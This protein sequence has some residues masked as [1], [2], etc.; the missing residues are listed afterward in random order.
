MGIYDRNRGVAGAR[1]NLWIR[2]TITEELRVKHGLKAREQREPSPEDNQRAA[3]ALLA[4]RNREVR[5]GSWQPASKGG[6]SGQTLREYATAWLDARLAAGVKS[7]RNERQRLVQ[8]V[9]PV[10]GDKRLGDVRRQDVRQLIADFA[11]TPSKTTGKPPAPR[12]VHRVYE[13]LR[14]LYAEAVEVDE[15]VPASPC[16]LKVRRGE[17][18]KKKDA[19]PRW[20]TNAVFSRDEVEMLISDERIDWPRRVTYALMFL[21]GSRIGEVCGLLWRDYDPTMR[22]LGRITVATTYGGEST[23][24]ETT[25]E[26]PVH[27]VLA[28]M[29]ASWKL[30]GFPLYLAR[31][32]RPDDYV[33]PRLRTRGGKPATIPHQDSRRVWV[34][35]QADLRMLGM[36]KR[37]VHDARRTLISLARADGATKDILDWITHGPSNE[38]MQDLYTT[39]PWSTFCEQLA[40]LRIELRKPAAVTALRPLSSAADH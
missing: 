40:V 5:D 4:Q 12:M 19:D 8:H 21:T 27:P 23:K 36:R 9:L 17:L 2:Y 35:L 11:R 10:L 13:D 22:P 18:P 37:R 29:L 24:S 39:F 33:V 6:G 28:S 30:Q 20:R 3:A 15:L 26:V 34:N 32:P 25:R 14:T 7:H 31:T 38:D 16:S 1:K